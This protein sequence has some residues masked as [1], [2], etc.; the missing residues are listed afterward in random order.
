M[1]Y[2]LGQTTHGVTRLKEELQVNIELVMTIQK[3]CISIKPIHQTHI[4]MRSAVKKY[5][6]KNTKM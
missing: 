3:L 5:L 1:L 4:L 6:H 2:R